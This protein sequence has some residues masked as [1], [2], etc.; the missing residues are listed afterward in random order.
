MDQLNILEEEGVDPARVII[1]HSGFEREPITYCLKLA[2]RGVTLGFDR[3]GNHKCYPDSHW[4]DLIRSM[5]EKGYLPHVVLSH[6][7][8]AYWAGGPEEL[9]SLCTFT[10]SY[11]LR[12]FV[13]RMLREGISEDKVNSILVENPQRVL[14]M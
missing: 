4:V 9:H 6:D 11:V 2:K 8:S 12:D 1:G 10:F 14:E 3:V 13:P 7:S 5:D